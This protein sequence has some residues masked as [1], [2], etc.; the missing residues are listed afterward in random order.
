MTTMRT[1]IAGG[2]LYTLACGGRASPAPPG[3]AAFQAQIAAEENAA[4]GAAATCKRAGDRFGLGTLPDALDAGKPAAGAT[5][6]VRSEGGGFAVRATLSSQDG[7]SFTVSGRMTTSGGSVQVSLVHD[8]ATL[9]SKMPCSIDFTGTYSGEVE[10][11]RVWAIA[12]CP[13]VGDPQGDECYAS[14]EFAF[15]NCDK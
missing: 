13:V 11:G 9:V 6:Q 8:G 7:T 2:A 5:C 1:A 3:Y 12:L 4:P 10:P 14:A 15:T